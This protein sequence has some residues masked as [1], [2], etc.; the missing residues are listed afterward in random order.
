MTAEE[1]QDALLNMFE[2]IAEVRDESE[3]EDDDGTQADYARDIASDLD[4][5]THA[6]TYGREMMM[7]RDSGLVVR[8]KDGAEFQITIVQSRHGR[9]D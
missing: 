1:L 8:T 5:V 7:T 6:V 4:E 9:D 3:G 2:T